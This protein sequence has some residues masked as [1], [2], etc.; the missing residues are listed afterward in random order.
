M[1]GACRL[2]VAALEVHDR[3]S[4]LMAFRHFFL[5][6]Y[7]FPLT[8]ERLTELQETLLEIEASAAKDLDRLDAFLKAL[9][10][11]SEFASE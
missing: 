10:Q 5:H 1:L 7:A 8:G 11:P 2:S 3:A 9:A 6:A 4:R